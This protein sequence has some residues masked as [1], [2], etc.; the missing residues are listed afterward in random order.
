MVL[1]IVERG[2]SNPWV[3]NV[4]KIGGMIDAL[5][6]TYMRVENRK[7]PKP[8]IVVERGKWLRDVSC[9]EVRWVQIRQAVQ[10][11]VSSGSAVCQVMGEMTGGGFAGVHYPLHAP[12][13][14]PCICIT[15]PLTFWLFLLMRIDWNGAFSNLFWL[16]EILKKYGNIAKKLLVARQQMERIQHNC[17]SV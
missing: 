4:H 11:D 3:K 10:L 8:V 12:P 6:A 17:L 13:I 1:H 2:G 15:W 9:G 14:R 7:M 5:S 16:Q